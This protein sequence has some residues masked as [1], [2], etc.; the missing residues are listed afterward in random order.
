METKDRF[1]SVEIFIKTK[2]NYKHELETPIVEHTVFKH[3]PARKVFFER[4]KSTRKCLFY[5]VIWINQNHFWLVLVL[6]DS[7]FQRI[8]YCF[9]VKKSHFRAHTWYFCVGSRNRRSI[10]SLFSHFFAVLEVVKKVSFFTKSHGLFGKTTRLNVFFTRFQKN[11]P[12][13]PGPN[14]CTLRNSWKYGISTPFF[15]VEIP[16]GTRL[17][18]KTLHP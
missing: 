12:S 8:K 6:G 1:L 13:F 17:V 7:S 11:G 2:N 16:Y 15:G 5:S 18:K 4:K 10:M 9:G 14:L 3:L